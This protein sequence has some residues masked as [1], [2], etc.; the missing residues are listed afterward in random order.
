MLS[1]NYAKIIRS[2]SHKK[3]RDK[4]GIFAAEG[5]KI[6]LDLLESGFDQVEHIFMTE[7]FYKSYPQKLV[8]WKPLIG[9]I[10]SSELQKISQFDSIPDIILI[11]KIPGMIDPNTVD[12]NKGIHLFLDRIQD[13]GNMGT[14]LRTAEWFGVNTIGLSIGCADFVHPKVIQASMGSFARVCIYHGNLPDAK[15]HKFAVMGADL[16]G[17][18]MYSLE[19]PA[20]GILVIGNEGGG[21][22]PMISSR[23][24]SKVMIPRFSPAIESLNAASATAILLAEWRRNITD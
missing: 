21:I 13:P 19:W 18:S 16:T 9:I 1:E 23:L 8:T 7:A 24:T 6:V 17:P 14:I 3:Y 2:L 20:A 11:G 22:D 15:N 12:F 5:A 10:G 4:H